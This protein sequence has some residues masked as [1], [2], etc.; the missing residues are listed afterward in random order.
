[1]SDLMQKE[2]GIAERLF[3]EGYLFDFFQ[4]V[5]LL[6]LFLPG[7]KSTGE[8]SDLKEERI[9][10][11]PHH[12]LAFPA[13][14]IRGIEKLDGTPESARI[15]VTFMGLYG[16][17][18]PLPGWFYEAIG[19]GADYA[20]PL[21]DFLDIFN[22]RLYSLFYRSWAKYRLF[23]Q[24]SRPTGRRALLLRALS[25]SG[26]GNPGSI[27]AIEIR[28][29][30]LAAFA[31]ILSFQV[32][33]AEGLR[34]VLAELLQDIPVAVLENVSRWVTI[35]E[36]A[37]LGRNG[38]R[39]LVLSVTSSIGRQVNDISGKFRVVLGPLTLGQYVALLP[40]GDRTRTVNSIV[41]LYVRDALD[42]D[43]Q[44]RL[45]TSEI[46]MLRLGDSALK[47]GLTTW[48]GRPRTETTSRLVDYGK[49]FH[50]LI[51]SGAV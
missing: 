46:P 3:Q 34:N 31:G 38:K 10:F 36:R 35:P 7:G 13:A 30:H 11:R 44:L 17:D 24:Y 19:N 22:H 51:P 32:R 27:D 41:R 29:V 18:S 21:R 26:L 6:E 33:N 15:T 39:S 42:Y 20:Q 48:L 14:D 28:P 8:T 40:G 47:I 25:L 2:A 16:V 23:E 49:H 45:K 50:S 1:L 43:V 37:R 12:G 9:R 4:S 5:R